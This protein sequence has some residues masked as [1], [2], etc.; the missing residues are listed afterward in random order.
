MLA[1]ACGPYTI[2]YGRMILAHHFNH[3]FHI[4]HPLL[5]MT[6]GENSADQH[7]IIRQHTNIIALEGLGVHS[8]NLLYGHFPVCLCCF[9]DAPEIWW[10]CPQTP[11]I[12]FVPW[13]L[14]LSCFL[15]LFL[16][17][18]GSQYS[19]AV[20]SL[21]DADLQNAQ[22]KVTAST[23]NAL[24]YSKHTTTRVHA[25]AFTPQ[26]VFGCGLLSDD[27]AKDWTR[28]CCKTSVPSQCHQYRT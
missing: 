5:I 2:G 28:R 1:S 20:I 17:S 9:H 7:H 18:P 8:M 27:L 14:S 22:S 4:M 19:L 16:L 3:Y 24:G 21:S 25:V 12:P 6:S 26:K 11:A 13:S 23:L 15:Q 10:T